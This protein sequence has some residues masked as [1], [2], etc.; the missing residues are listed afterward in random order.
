M[1]S[2]FVPTCLETGIQFLPLCWTCWYWYWYDT[3]RS[4]LVWRLYQWQT[5]TLSKTLEMQ[6]TTCEMRYLRRAVNKTR[7]DMI[8]NEKIREMVRPAPTIQHVAKQRIKWFGRLSRTAVSRPASRVYKKCQVFWLQSPRETPKAL[9][10]QR[11]RNPQDLWHVCDPG[12]SA[13]CVPP[14]SSP[15]RHPVQAHGK[16]NQGVLTSD[17]EEDPEGAGLMA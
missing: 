1:H 10:W 15:R 7:R 8:R 13:C 12:F 2:R 11:S 6:L 3:G 14:A 16:S 4:V 17:P 9:D 5:W